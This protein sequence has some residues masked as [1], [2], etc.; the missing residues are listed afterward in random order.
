MIYG[1]IAKILR[2][3]NKKC[4]KTN[5]MNK[6]RDKRVS[7]CTVASM[8]CGSLI[9]QEARLSMEQPTDISLCMVHTK[10]QKNSVAYF[11]LTWFVWMRCWVAYIELYV[12]LHDSMIHNTMLHYRCF[13]KIVLWKLFQA[14]RLLELCQYGRPVSTKMYVPLW[15]FELGSCWDSQCL[16]SSLSFIALRSKQSMQNA[17]REPSNSETALKQWM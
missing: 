4:C 17:T 13:F 15:Q 16:F 9:R 5:I 1:K 10:V 11:T 2:K 12:W 7:E 6:M 14:V 8:I 3:W